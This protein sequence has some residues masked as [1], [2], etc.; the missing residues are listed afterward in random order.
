MLE[1]Y[2][3]MYLETGGLMTPLIGRLISDAGYDKEYSLT[4]KSTLVSPPAW[5]DVL[6][7]KHPELTVREPVL[8]DFGAAGK[9]YL[10]DIVSDILTA[11]NIKNYCIDAGGDILH[12][13]A[14]LLRV[15]LE[16]PED[17][18]QAIGVVEIV[19]QS[20]CGSSGNR[21]AWGRFH[22]IINPST[23]SSPTEITSIWVI[24]DSTILADALTTALFFA[25]ADKLQKLFG[26]EYLILKADFSIERSV[27]FKAEL[28]TQ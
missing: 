8:L 10:I 9:G 6:S 14:E 13:G 25:R 2:R 15:G 26:F 17:I 23:M 4:E 5:D 7:Y 22:H 19:N 3:Q 24:A 1:L 20:I 12:R 28:F 11:Q 16:N 21:R 18:D 27:G